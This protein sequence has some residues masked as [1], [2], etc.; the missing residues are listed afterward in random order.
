MRARTENG[1]QKI[2][3]KY[4]ECGF[5]PR[6]LRDAVDRLKAT[7]T[8]ER[9]QGSGPK[10]RIRTA[11]K[12]EAA[13]AYMGSNPDASCG[14]LVKEM[15]IKRTSARNI[16][17]RDLDLKP[18]KKT[19]SHRVTQRNKTKRMEACQTWDADIASGALDLTKVFFTDEEI[20]RLGACAGGN[21]NLVVWVS[22]NLKKA[23]LPNDLILREDGKWQGGARAMV[24]LG[25]CYRGVGTLRFSPQGAKINSAAYQE[26]VENTYLP[27]CAEFYGAPPECVFQQDGASSRNSAATQAFVKDR[28]PNFRQKGQWPA[29]S[30]DLNPLD[31]FY[32]GYLQR[33]AGKKK[34]SCLNTLKVAIRQSAAATPLDMAQR[35]ILD[36]AKR[37]KLCLQ[38]GGEVFKDRHL[39]N[40]PADVAP[41]AEVDMPPV[42]HEPENGDDEEEDADN[43]DHPLVN[44]E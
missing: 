15:G 28:F 25:M 26:I 5:N 36:F 12:I 19:T 34:P 24:S 20:F 35:A 40:V 2:L 42:D 11:D 23:D 1:I 18:L 7:G 29:S 14:D 30:P 39:A 8:L 16:L 31:Y 37:A 44:D 10:R 32:W 22:S 4:P 33:E 38:M 9:K 21:Q 6:G 43:E 41:D 27:D 17:K 13:R 3:K